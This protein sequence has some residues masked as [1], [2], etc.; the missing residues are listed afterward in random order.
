MGMGK[1][2]ADLGREIGSGSREGITVCG[3]H[4]YVRKPLKYQCFL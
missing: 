1:I 3:E 2:G 4:H